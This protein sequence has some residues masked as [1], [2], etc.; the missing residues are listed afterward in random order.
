MV[1]KL[2]VGI[3]GHIRKNIVKTNNKM[4]TSCLRFECDKNFLKIVKTNN[5]NKTN[6]T[7]PVSEIISKIYYEDEWSIFV[8]LKQTL[9][10][11]ILY[12][13]KLL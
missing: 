7:I 12:H 5:R 10:F 2:P 4:K 11:H 1:K 3:I 6:P 9:N 8:F 13:Y